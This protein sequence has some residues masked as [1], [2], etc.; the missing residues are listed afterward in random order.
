MTHDN[1]T[2]F[3]ELSW[4]EAGLLPVVAQDRHSGVVCMVAWADR[5]ALTATLET[6]QAHFYSRSRR[7]LWKKG[8]TSGNVLQVFEVW[9][10]CDMDTVIYLVEPSGP[11]CHLGHP[12]CFF[13]VLSDGGVTPVGDVQR[14]EKDASPALPVARP[15]LSALEEALQERVNASG[16][17]SYTKSLLEA[18][19]EKIGAKI[20]EEAEELVQAV[21]GESDARVASEA[22]DV[23]YHLMVGLLHRGIPLRAVEQELA[24]RFGTSGHEEKASRSDKA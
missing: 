7:T 11:S 18:G 20:N 12:T 17:R 6:S 10:D 14:A 13:R 23:L 15:T 24:R 8:E 19:A 16:Q 1:D 4:N 3:A 5:T 22:A 21:A 2:R 9:T